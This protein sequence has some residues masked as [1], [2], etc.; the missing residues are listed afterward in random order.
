MGYFAEE[1]K[2][3]VRELILSMSPSSVTSR[4]VSQICFKGPNVFV[5]YLN[6]EEKTKEALD[7][8]G[9]LHSGIVLLS[10]G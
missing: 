8:D 4:V 6:N 5:G 9:W 10:T 2:G 3:E 7:E 1:D